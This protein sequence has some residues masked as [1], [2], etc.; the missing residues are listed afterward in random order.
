MPK[1]KKDV[2]P[3]FIAPHALTGDAKGNRYVLEWGPYGRVRKF[4][5]TP[6]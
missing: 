4:A 2:S 1:E 3:E 6:A 5:P